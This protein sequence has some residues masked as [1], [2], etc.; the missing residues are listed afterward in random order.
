MKS[1]S[2]V[3]AAAC[4]AAALFATAVV[5]QT[6]PV[7]PIRLIVGFAPGGGND[8]IARVLAEPI[9]QA[10][11]QQ[12]IVENR[13]GANSIVAAQYSAK[14]PPDGYTLLFAGSGPMTINP[15]IYSRL[16]Y[17]S[18]K[19]FVP[20]GMVG[21]LGALIIARS[22][23]EAGTLAEVVKLAR[24]KPGRLTYGAGSTS[25]QITAEAFSREAGISLL[26][27]P[28]KG[29]SPAVQAAAAG[30]IDL[31]FVDTTGVGSM[32]SAGRI[33][34]IAMT[35]EPRPSN[36]PGVP[37]V[38]E[39]GMPN[40]D[41]NFFLAIFAPAGTPPA[42]VDRLNAE[43]VKALKLPAVHDRMMSLGIRPA[44]STPGELAGRVRR[45][46]QYFSAIAKSANIKV[47]TP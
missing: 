13:P 30:E 37:T 14:A 22:S 46:I 2:V 42:I 23:L 12:V 7:K 4:L 36:L 8:I 19:D 6:Y 20:L 27:V 25:F 28:Y 18:Q 29:T 45:D 31:A 11:G 39:A 41:F 5:A 1:K 44:A 33:K 15:A 16:P 9:G 26:H 35:S 47:E 34:A 3:A 40:F 10:L 43:I 38:I 17:D 24:E 21:T 32:L